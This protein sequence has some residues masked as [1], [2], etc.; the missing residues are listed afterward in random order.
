MPKLY[1]DNGGNV[2]GPNPS[3]DNAIVRFDGTTGLEIQDSTATISD[4]GEVAFQTT[5]NTATAFQQLSAAGD[6]I[7][8]INSVVP[9]LAGGG[10]VAQLAGNGDTAYG[11]SGSFIRVLRVRNRINTGT[12]TGAVRGVDSILVFEGDVV[13]T[14]DNI[15]RGFNANCVWNSTGTATTLVGMQNFMAFSGGGASNPSG[16]VDEAIANRATIGVNTS[17]SGSVTDGICFQADSPTRVDANRTITNAYGFSA[18]DQMVTGAVTNSWAL[19]IEDQTSP[20]FAIQTGTG[21]SQFGDQVIIDATNAEALLIRQ[22]ADAAD[23]I[24]FNTQV[25]ATAGSNTR[26]MEIVTGGEAQAGSIY[27]VIGGDI[28]AEIKTGTHSSSLYGMNVETT[29]SSDGVKSGTFG[30]HQAGI[31]FISYHNSTGTNE[32]IYGIVGKTVLGGPGS[33][34]NLGLVTNG[35]GMRFG[36]EFSTAGTGSATNMHGVYINAPTGSTT[37][38]KTVTNNYG[39]FLED[40]TDTGITNAYAIKT[41]TGRHLY[42]GSIELPYV[43]KTGTYTIGANDHTVD[44]TANTFTVTLPTAVGITGRIYNIKNSGAGVITVDGAGTETIDGALTVTV[45]AGS[46]GNKPNLQ[47]QSTGAN[48]IIL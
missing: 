26:T 3:T 9:N 29:I 43:A 16:L 19:K 8:Y 42:G 36:W 12:Q 17:L 2:I 14:G 46:T 34:T 21:V 37:P 40:Q 41:G 6:Q 23:V 25:A 13:L 35:Y 20:G 11:G 32:E 7:L 39:L 5:T 22:N 38:G 28:K 45:P 15:A 33:S 24:T 10:I 31:N 1:G 4:L 27:Q 30:N 44:C 18:E 47:I 48:W